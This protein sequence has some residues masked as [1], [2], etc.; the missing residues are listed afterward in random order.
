MGLPLGYTLIAETIT[1]VNDFELSLE[2]HI[3][4]V[5]NILAATQWEIFRIMLG[6]QTKHPL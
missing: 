2:L 1:V 5:L 3:I 6:R 4:S